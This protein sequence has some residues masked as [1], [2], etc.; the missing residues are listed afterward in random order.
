[1][2]HWL[3]GENTARLDRSCVQ[4]IYAWLRLLAVESGILEPDEAPHR[5][6]T[7]VAPLSKGAV[8]T[9]QPYVDPA[10]GI[11]F[12]FVSGGEFSMGD[13]FG[14]GID[15]EKPVHQVSLSSFYMAASPV[16]QAQ[17][18][19]LM[20]ENPS[21]FTG[22]DHPVEQVQ[23]SDVIEFVNKLNANSP[24]GMRFDLPSEAQWEYAARSGGLEQLYA[25]GQDPEPVAWFEGN[26]NDGTAPVCTK[27]P[28]GLGLYDLSGNVWE[29][30][31]DIYQSD[32]YRYHTQ[33]D[34]VCTQGGKDR[35]I[36]GGS[37]NLDAWSARCSRRFRF[38]PDLYGP[39]LGFRLVMEGRAKGFEESRGQGVEGN[40]KE[41]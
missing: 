17:W 31:R 3:A 11:A 6:P 40:A 36:R 37:W 29:W 23:L 5:S 38:N 9:G 2:A 20:A 22:P 13:T 26:S 28:N 8:E 21:N 1:M 24:Q 15:D 25:G 14:D 39:G 16:T 19:C 4:F 10:T 12:V 33:T 35:I 32:A 34:P 18:E 41:L 30:C 7:I 27:Q